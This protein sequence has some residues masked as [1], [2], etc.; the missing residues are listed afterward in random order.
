[1]RKKRAT[2]PEFAERDRE[3]HREWEQKKRAADPEWAERE[4]ERKTDWYWNLSGFQRNLRFLKASCRQRSARVE[5]RRERTRRLDEED[6]LFFENLARETGMDL[7][8]LRLDDLQMGPLLR[9]LEADIVKN[10]ER[11]RVSRESAKLPGLPRNT[12]A[13]CD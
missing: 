12:S 9:E 10:I 8:P 6:R 11:G 13:A 4:R 1:M 2:D 7:A 3:R 5:M